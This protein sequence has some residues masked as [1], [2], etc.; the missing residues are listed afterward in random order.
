MR[1]ALGIL[2]I[3][4]L[5]I[6]L[7]GGVF[8]A[9]QPTITVPLEESV[10]P[11]VTITVDN[12]SSTLQEM[13]VTAG[14]SWKGGANRSLYPVA[15]LL[16][17]DTTATRWYFG[18]SVPTALVGHKFPADGSWNELGV[19]SLASM[20]GITTGS[21]ASCAVTLKYRPKY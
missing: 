7:A 8:A 21:D 11:S 10:N 15:L 4:F 2:A 13:V 20:R 14:G 3:P 5:A 6:L 16:T 12:T 9:E 19:E 17:C 18:G 1:K